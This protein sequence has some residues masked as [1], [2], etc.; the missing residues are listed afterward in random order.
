MSEQRLVDIES[1]L[2]YQE[3]LIE[4]LNRV[5]TAQQSTISTLEAAV[6]ILAKNSRNPEAKHPGPADQKPPHY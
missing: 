1:K 6:K 4:K 5:I 2:A 3:D